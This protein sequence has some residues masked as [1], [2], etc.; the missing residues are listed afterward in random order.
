MQSSYYREKITNQPYIQ[1]GLYEPFKIS[2][3]R[4][5]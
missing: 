5:S 1:Q 4:V 2:I 3:Y